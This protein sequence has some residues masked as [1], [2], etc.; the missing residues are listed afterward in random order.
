MGTHHEWDQHAF[1]LIVLHSPHPQRSLFYGSRY[2]YHAVAMNR[3]ETAERSDLKAQPRGQYEKFKFGQKT[4]AGLEDGAGDVRQPRSDAP[5]S[6]SGGLANK[7]VQLLNRLAVPD[8]AVDRGHTVLPGVSDREEAG[9][10][11]RACALQ[12]KADA[13]Q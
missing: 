6:P 3:E 2:C 11:C 12:V 9:A 1:R 7:L 10:T 4:E 8:S 5:V 13:Q